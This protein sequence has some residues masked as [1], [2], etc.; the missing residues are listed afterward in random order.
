MLIVAPGAARG[1][2]VPSPVAQID[3]FPTLAEW[4]GVK[5]PA[6]V[7]GQSLVPMLK[8]PTVTGRGW[9]LT[10]VVRGGGIQRFGA[11]AAIGDGGKRYFGYSLRTPRWRY[12]E[13]DEGAQ[14]RELYDHNADPRELTN[15]AEKPEHAETVADLS[16]QLRAAVQAT[17]PPSGKVP[18]IQ[19]GLGRRTSP[20]RDVVGSAS[21]AAYPGRVSDR[22]LAQKLCRRGGYHRRPRF[23]HGGQATRAGTCGK[24]RCCLA[25]RPREEATG[26]RPPHSRRSLRCPN[27][28]RSIVGV[29]G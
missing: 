24:L 18:E 26:L 2:A 15:L 12:T 19:P 29:C 9:A 25:G 17:L 27:G 14:G 23:A 21:K 4:C 22:L 10:Q 5:V 8:D 28:Q 11:S 16:Q 1:I 7:Q 6:N 13:W 3:L 20:S